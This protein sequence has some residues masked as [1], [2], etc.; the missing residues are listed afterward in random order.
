MSERQNRF[1]SNYAIGDGCDTPPDEWRSHEKAQQNEVHYNNDEVNRMGQ[2][3]EDR[4]DAILNRTDARERK[5]D[6]RLEE[7]FSSLKKLSLTATAGEVTPDS[8]KANSDSA[9][10]RG[11]YD[12]GP[13]DQL[14][15]GGNNNP[16]ERNSE[17]EQYRSTPYPPR[18][19]IP[20]MLPMSDTPVPTSS[21]RVVTFDEIGNEFP[22]NNRRG[23]AEE[24]PRYPENTGKSLGE[25]STGTRL[26]PWKQTF[27]TDLAADVFEYVHQFEVYSVAASW[28]EDVQVASFQSTLKGRAAQI[29]RSLLTKCDWKTV[30]KTL[31]AAWEPEERRK[32]LRE[33]FTTA[34]RNKK[35]SAEEFLVRITQ[36]AS[37][38]FIDYPDKL[39]SEMVRTAFVRGQTESIQKSLASSLTADVNDLLAIIIR[40]ESVRPVEVART[41]VSRA[42][43]T[44]T[45]T[46]DDDETYEVRKAYTVEAET[47]HEESLKPKAITA[48]AKDWVQIALAATPTEGDG[49]YDEPAIY[50][51]LQATAV[52]REDRQTSKGA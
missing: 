34:R 22:M 50:R 51:V 25:S 16:S 32:V 49:S 46:D 37:R 18:I 5:V 11:C 36:T 33:N 45:T 24:V 40:L 26:L 38:T 3:F 15:T 48:D 43:L 21:D 7:I 13:Q 6:V 44:A 20:S 12:R 23:V 52:V 39:R 9:S 1:A 2:A 8:S 17:Q 47:D 35:E 14:S 29:V 10:I 28:D 27:G 30:V 41:T 4:I 19:G 42:Q 31:Q